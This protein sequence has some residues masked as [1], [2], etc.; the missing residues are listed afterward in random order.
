[1]SGERATTG[2]VLW[3]RACAA[4]RSRIGERNFATWIAP[5]QP[6]WAQGTLALGA[7]DAATRDRVA[8]HFLAA[9]EAAV[10]EAAGGSCVVRL[11]VASA[12]PVLPIPKR[13][14]SRDQTFDRFVRGASNAEAWAAARALVER[15]DG[16]PLFLHGPSGVGKTHLLHAIFHALDGA[17]LL[18]VCL[19][20]AQLVDALLAAYAARADDRFWADLAPLSALLLDDVHSIRGREETQ[21]R[22]VDG[23]GAW[24]RAGRLL[25]LTS[26]RAPGDVPALLGRLGDAY[27]RPTV[28][29]IAPPEPTLCAAIL[30]QKARDQGVALEPR[31]AARLAAHVDGNVRRLE[32]ALTRLLAHARLSGRTLDESLARE[33]LPD[34]ARRVAPPGLERIV[35]VTAAAFRLPPRRLRGAG[36]SP[37]VVLARRLAMLVARRVAGTSF[38]ELGRA[39][40]RD[41]TTAMHG[42]RAI[43]ARLAVEPTL[44]A[45]VA[46]IEERLR[47]GD[48][49]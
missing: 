5:L 24:V 29:A 19:S 32:G 48:G 22:L 27:F 36:R 6:S 47:V 12:P 43:E 41:H 38:A 40:G 13:L 17:G 28:A 45:I 16:S 7:P 4:L 26:D 14:P 46:R 3:G 9:I 39:F 8:R 42:C 49:G 11:A 25:V 10:A 33:V 23:L 18:T 21:Q 34:L 1:M 44:R 15:G 31:L 37:D 30:Q 20:A 2:P 35:A